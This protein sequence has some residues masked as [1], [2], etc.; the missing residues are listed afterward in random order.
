METSNKDFIDNTFVDPTPKVTQQLLENIMRMGWSEKIIDSFLE[1]CLIIGDIKTF[2]GMYL[3]ELNEA[4][5]NPFRKHPKE[6]LTYTTDE[7]NWNELTYKE[8]EDR[9]NGIDPEITPGF[10]DLNKEN[11]DELVDNLEKDIMFR[12]DSEAYIING[13]IRFYKEKTALD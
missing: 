7:E 10:I 2:K 4:I 3:N 12:S 9:L 1:N 5:W 8:K 13:L 6:E 11:F